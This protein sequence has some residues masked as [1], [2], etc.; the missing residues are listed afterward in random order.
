M[1]KKDELRQEIQI[2][3]EILTLAKE[4]YSYSNYIRN[5]ET[6]QEIKYIAKSRDFRFMSHAF[7]RLCIIE[8]SKLFSNN[9]DT[10]K[11]NINKLISKLKSDGHYRSL[12]FNQTAISL[13]EQKIKDNCNAIEIVQK[14]RNEVYSHK[15]RNSNL[16][17]ANDLTFK[18]VANLIQI[19]SEIVKSIYSECFD[20]DALVR[21]VY[22]HDGRFNI[23]KILAEEKEIRIKK[24]IDKLL[25]NVK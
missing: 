11:F 25:G 4:C 16:D 8:L 14:L 3:W 5:P 20:T 23:I 1:T 24:K 7:W 6:I 2:I 15:D 22:F 13:W 12:K 17:Y 9:N 10:H 21:T 18:E 19:V